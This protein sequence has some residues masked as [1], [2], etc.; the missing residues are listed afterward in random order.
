MHSMVHPFYRK[1]R[2]ILAI[3][4]PALVESSYLPLRQLFKNFEAAE[5]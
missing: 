5:E 1:K 4:G 2:G 3:I